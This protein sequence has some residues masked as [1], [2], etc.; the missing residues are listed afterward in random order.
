MD[1]AGLQDELT[2]VVRTWDDRL[3]SEPGGAALAAQLAGVPEAYKAIT[4]PARAVEDLTRIAALAG[5]VDFAVRLCPAD[6]PA[7]RRFTLYLASTPATL[8]DVLPLLQQLGLDVLD[9]RPSEFVRADGLRV[10]VYDFS[11]R[12]DDAT[13]TALDARPEADIEREFCAAFGAAWRGDVE[14][15]RFSALVL[16]AGLPWREVAV[17]RAYARYAR[18]IG[19]LVRR[20]STWR[21]RCSRTPTSRAGWWRSSGPGSTRRCSIA[22]RRSRPPSPTCAPGSTPSPGWTPTGS[23]AAS[24]R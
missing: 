5:P 8:T 6:G 15:D 24:S 20:R 4:P 12:L 14:T 19:A 22:R 3:L 18:Q 17:L 16:R 9:E 11:I 21:T 23:C 13:R 2:E 10:H 1:V 7:D